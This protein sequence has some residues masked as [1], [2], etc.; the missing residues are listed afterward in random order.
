MSNRYMVGIDVGTTGTKT[1][2]FDME[3]RTVAKA[4]TEYGSIYPR[5]GWVE[6]DAFLIREATLATC[7]TA[8][9]G[10]GIRGEDIASFGL[11]T[12]RACAIFLDSDGTPL[13]MFSWQ[14]ARA[15]KESAS[16]AALISDEEFYRINGVPNDPAWIVPKMMWVRE[17]EPR[18]WER[19]RKVVQLHDYI[20]KAL[21]AEDY[22]CDET[23]AG[24]FCVWDCDRFC[25]HRG[26]IDLF[27]VDMSLLPEV[28]RTGERVGTVSREVAERTGLPV[29]LAVCVGLGDQTGAS[30]GAGVVSPGKFSISM[31]TGGMCLGFLDKPYRD[32]KGSFMIVDHAIHGCWELEGW[33][34][35]GAG[36]YRWFRDNIATLEK[37]NAE[38]DGTD[39]YEVLNEMIAAIPAGAKGLITM[40]YFATAGT[41]RWNENARGTIMG[42]SYYHD[43][44]CMARSVMEGITL[45]YKDMLA[46]LKSSDIAVDSACIIG[47]PTKSELWNQIQADVYGIPV[48]K[49]RFADASVLGSAIAGAYSAGLFGSIAEGAGRLV[50]IQKVYEPNPEA[51]SV[52]DELYGIYCRIYEGLES[53]GVYDAIAAFQ[54]KTV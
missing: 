24:F 45:E 6:Q 26:L 30:V 5:P 51:T 39:V 33:Q 47:G 1:V 29:G 27:R 10:S 31:G 19:T 42:L 34:K 21:G 22:Y 7:R 44:A 28:R 11:S 25:W 37:Q 13:K 38:K 41:P 36:I 49:P 35:G 9:V 2:V 17:N 50:Q 16:L 46:C 48:Y 40:P 15:E 52:Y 8:I 43:K 23:D 20:L 4:Y 54:K 12:Q 53:H 18:I 14:D 32:P 3:G